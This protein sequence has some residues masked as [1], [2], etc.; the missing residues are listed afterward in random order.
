MHPYSIDVWSSLRHCSKL[1]CPKV[2]RTVP[3]PTQL[4]ILLYFDPY[5]SFP[6]CISVPEAQVNKTPITFL[7]QN[8]NLIDVTSNL[9]YF[10]SV[11][12]SNTQLKFVDT[13]WQ[14][15]DNKLLT[16]AMWWYCHILIWVAAL[17][18]DL[19]F[20]IWRAPSCGHAFPCEVKNEWTYTYKK[21][22]A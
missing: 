7:A 5:L 18:C 2:T 21:L 13:L 15:L 22:H 17:W 14:K 4:R 8:G 20:G 1:S 3:P 11:N 10:L 19:P 9:V 16:K 12:I 6:I